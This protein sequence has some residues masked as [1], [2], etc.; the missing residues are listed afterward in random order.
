MQVLSALECVFEVITM[1]ESSL[2][3]QCRK[4]MQ[5]VR[6]TL[7]NDE[8]RSQGVIQQNSSR[9]ISQSSKYCTQN[10]SSLLWF[11]LD[12]FQILSFVFLFFSKQLLIFV[13]YLKC[14]GVL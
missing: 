2:A 8:L 3:R 12:F 7:Q 1:A 13:L 10:T 6:V 4:C 14:S 5:N 11:I 9:H